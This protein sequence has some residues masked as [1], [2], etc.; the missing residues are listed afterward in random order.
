M[1]EPQNGVG[2][3]FPITGSMQAV[4]RQL[5]D[6]DLVKWKAPNRYISHAWM[7]E[8]QSSL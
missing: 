8:L 5:F 3:E 6:L 7:I 4:V 2:D 1:K